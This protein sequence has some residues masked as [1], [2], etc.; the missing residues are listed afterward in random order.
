[1]FLGRRDRARALVAA[2]GVGR[3]SLSSERR[4]RSFVVREGGG[5]EGGNES[6]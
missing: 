2:S 4:R 1:M 3:L 6:V 5:G